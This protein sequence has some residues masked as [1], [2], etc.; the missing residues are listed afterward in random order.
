MA[1]ARALHY[2]VITEPWAMYLFQHLQQ[3]RGPTASKLCNRCFLT[4]LPTLFCC[5]APPRCCY[6]SF[7][8]ATRA[9]PYTTYSSIFQLHLPDNIVCILAP[10]L[11]LEHIQESSPLQEHTCECSCK[12]IFPSTRV[13]SHANAYLPS[14][15]NL[16]PL[17]CMLSL[18]NIG[19]ILFH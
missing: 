19:A 8:S 5:H 16:P 13:H 12:E 11:A 1:T 2:Q 6:L 10:H 4:S 9:L 14:S 3:A 17:N 18:H 7:P 15:P